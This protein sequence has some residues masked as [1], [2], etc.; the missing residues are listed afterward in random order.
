MSPKMRKWSLENLWLPRRCPGAAIVEK[1]LEFPLPHP[2]PQEEEPAFLLFTYV[3]PATIS[4]QK[5]IWGFPS[6]LSR[7]ELIL[8]SIHEDVGSI[9]GLAQWVK[10]PMFYEL[11]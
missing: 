9:P 4:F 2:T 8:T 10:D 11:W 1:R 5:R 7:R 3:F 6:W